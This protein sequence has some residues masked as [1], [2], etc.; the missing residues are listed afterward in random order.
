MSDQVMSLEK[1]VETGMLHSYVLGDLGP[2]ERAL[3]ELHLETYPSLRDELGYMENCL[4][5]IARQNAVTPKTTAAQLLDRVDNGGAA[6]NATGSPIWPWYLVLGLLAGL[7]YSVWSHWNTDQDLQASRKAYAALEK[8]CQE[9]NQEQQAAFAFF[10]DPSSQQLVLST[11][12]DV[13]GEV[14]FFWNDKVKKACISS[15]S[16]PT[17]DDDHDYQLWGDVDGEMI[18]IAL[19]P[20][21]R[22]GQVDL[23]YL[24]DVESLNITIEPRGGSDHPTVSRLIGSVRVS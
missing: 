22:A 6:S 1:F 14:V 12:D 24:E 23:S 19:I 18:S 17:L 11:S 3:V 10:Q 7:A 8:D 13:S 5:N 4:E 16:L 20:R 2:D 21:S 15:M 9:Q